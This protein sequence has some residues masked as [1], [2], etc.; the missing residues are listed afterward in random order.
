MKE[1]TKGTRYVLGNGF[2]R[3][4]GLDTS[5]DTFLEILKNED[6]YNETETAEI[7]FKRY[8]VLWGDYESCLADIDLEQ[9]VDDQ[10]IAP[11]YLSDHEYDRD[12]GIFNME[13][14]T[15][16]LRGA[17]QNSLKIMVDNANKELA[18]KTPL[19]IDFLKDNDAV[20]SFNYTSTL[21][22][23]YDA[24]IGVPI[25]HIH[26]FREYGEPLLL[27]YRNGITEEEYYNRVFDRET[28]EK[29]QNQIEEI[30]NDD[31]LSECEKEQELLYWYSVYDE[32]TRDRDYYIDTQYEVVYGFYQSL[33]KEVQI[34]QLRD[35]LKECGKIERVVVMGHSMSSVDSEYMEAIEETLIPT[36]WRISQYQDDP[37]WK[38]VKE[39][40]FSGKISFYDLVNEFAR[41]Q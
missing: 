39:Y 30:Q 22:R 19:L 26:G 12:S 1:D 9:I 23:L 2:D 33:K 24:P 8:N 37:S 38:S 14:Y 7:V 31:L 17:V 40:S 29:V 21:E 28:I 16:S 13:Q 4:H 15:E 5:P 27:G 20:L 35:F 11:D 36:E 34:D 10:M 41:E 25:C 32:V 3:F 18:V 6:I